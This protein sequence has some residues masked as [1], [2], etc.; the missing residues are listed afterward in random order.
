MMRPCLRPGCA[1][2]PTRRAAL[3]STCRRDYRYCSACGVV[4]LRS[5]HGARC[6]CRAC[7]VATYNPEKRRAR[8]LRNEAPPPPPPEPPPSLDLIAVRTLRQLRLLFGVHQATTELWV[9]SGWLPTFIEPAGRY[10]RVMVRDSDLRAFLACRE[11]WATWEVS[12][13]TDA[14]WQRDAMAARQPGRWL[15]VSEVL[16]Q[17]W[18]KPSLHKAIRQGRLPATRIGGWLRIWS[19]DWERWKHQYRG[20]AS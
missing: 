20:V 10:R 9:A 5:E 16:G 19:G 6:R 18:A 12:R 2:P 7:E 4:R 1:A 13:I 8:Y 3:C 15:L 11:A 14:D 17:G